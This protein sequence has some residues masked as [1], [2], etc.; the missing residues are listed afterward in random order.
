MKKMK[1]P[2][3]E[4][5]EFK[6]QLWDTAGQVKIANFPDISGIHICFPMLHFRRFNYMSVFSH[7]FLAALAT[8]Y[9]SNG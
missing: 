3:E 8:L 6:M 5:K 2:L 9:L 1:H 4:G 7:I